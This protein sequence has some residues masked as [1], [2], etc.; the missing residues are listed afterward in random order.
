MSRRKKTLLIV[1]A[2]G[3]ALAGLGTAGFA[4]AVGKIGDHVRG[5]QAFVLGWARASNHPQ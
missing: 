1:A 3:V 2:V 5:W 4:V